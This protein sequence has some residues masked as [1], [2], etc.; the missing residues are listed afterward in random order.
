MFSSA[1]FFS[2]Q[3]TIAS[4]LRQYKNTQSV[5]QRLV[6]LP[7]PHRAVGD[8]V[9]FADRSTL[10]IYVVPEI[11]HSPTKA[12]EQVKLRATAAN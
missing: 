4:V 1:T 5:M 11:N 7:F 12:A 10:L 6:R 9:L 2:R 8:A 3:V